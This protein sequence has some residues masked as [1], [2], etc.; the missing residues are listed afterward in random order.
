LCFGV[1]CWHIWGQCK[2]FCRRTIRP[3]L[4]SVLV[5]MPV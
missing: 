1:F 5:S 2:N 4:F 3:T